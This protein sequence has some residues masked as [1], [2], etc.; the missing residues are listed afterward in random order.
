[1]CP[2][3]FLRASYGSRTDP[4]AEDGAIN[5]AAMMAIC[6]PANELN[7]Y[8]D[9]TVNPVKP[10]GETDSRAVG[11]YIPIVELCLTKARADLHLY[12]SLEN[13]MATKKEVEVLIC[14]SISKYRKKHLEERH[15]YAK[16]RLASF[17]VSGNVA[18]HLLPEFRIFRP[19][20][21]CVLLPGA[22]Y[23]CRSDPTHRSSRSFTQHRDTG[24]A[25]TRS[26]WAA[27]KSGMAWYQIRR[28]RPKKPRNG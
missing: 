22:F 5:T 18:H 12:M 15:P 7:D 9:M 13:C 17:P 14:E 11:H 20:I 23:T 8:P 28:W 1:M 24:A 21:S 6:Q 3:L 10:D 16:S 27:S 19:M 26:S 2:R 25:S 4:P